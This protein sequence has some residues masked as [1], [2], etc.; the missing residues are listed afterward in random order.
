MPQWLSR[1]SARRTVAGLGV[2]TLVALAA[3][4]ALAQEGFTIGE[5]RAVPPAGLTVEAQRT[6]YW[7]VAPGAGRLTAYALD[8]AGEPL[9]S[10][11]SFDYA[12]SLQ[13][14]A[15]RSPH[16][17]LGDVGGVRRIV[18]V[19]RMEGPVPTT[20]IHRATPF[21]LRYPDGS[22]NAGTILVD[23]DRRL[24]VVTKGTPGA[25]YRAPERPSDEQTNDLELVGEAPDGVTDGV[26]LFDGRVVLRSA[27]RLFTLDPDTWEVVDD[28]RI[29]GQPEG[30]ALAQE[31]DGAG[32][33][34]GADAAGRVVALEVPG[35][36]PATP[37]PVPTEAVR[38][39]APTGTEDNPAITQT[40]TTASLLAAAVVAALAG[41]VVLLKR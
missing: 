27:T 15:F 26:V 40:G 16:L 12:Q 20:S 31:L 17:Y 41:L 37:A 14:V 2:A 33:L 1:A 6:R 39:P 19:W 29:P 8:R 3:P 10:V 24:Y 38:T 18:T 7:A 30:A 32:V 22:H 35:P 34:A 28:A 4:A 25:I 21:R 5:P 9:G 36:T 13:A 23:L 11:D